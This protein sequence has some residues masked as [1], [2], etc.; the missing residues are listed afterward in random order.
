MVGERCDL[1][2]SPHRCCSYSFQSAWVPSCQGTGP[3]GRVL[4]PGSAAAAGGLQ[5]HATAGVGRSCCS[6]AAQASPVGGGWGPV[7]A[8]GQVQVGRSSGSSWTAAAGPLRCSGGG[9]PDGPPCA[10]AH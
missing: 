9:S 4:S 8:C 1:A 7:R 10:A 5:G 6:A 2:S 3:V